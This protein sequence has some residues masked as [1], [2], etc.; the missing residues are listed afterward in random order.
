MLQGRQNHTHHVGD[1]GDQF[2]TSKAANPIPPKPGGLGGLAHHSNQIKTANPV[3]IKSGHLGHLPGKGVDGG[4]LAVASPF[5]EKLHDLL[6]Q[7]FIDL[8]LQARAQE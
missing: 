2:L 7:P 3:G 5:R 8:G 1:L 6:H 4:S